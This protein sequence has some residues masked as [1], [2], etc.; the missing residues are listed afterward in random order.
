LPAGETGIQNGARKGKAGYSPRLIVLV[1]TLILG[2]LI[3]G[4][5]KN[6]PL[7]FWAF[8]FYDDF[9]VCLR[10]FIV[11]AP[12][13]ITWL[14][15]HFLMKKPL[16]GS[17]VSKLSFRLPSW[18]FP[19]LLILFFF[20]LFWYLREARLWGD[21]GWTVRMLEGKHAIKPLGQYFWKEPLDR[22]AAIFFYRL[23]HGIWGW[24]PGPAW[25]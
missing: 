8:F 7:G 23:S 2:G 17:L 5:A 9:P 20:S 10:V 3:F 14:I 22:L 24:G 6:P 1:S 19:V 13:L 11:L 25:P 21:G 12:A 15:Y 18:L 16:S 4:A